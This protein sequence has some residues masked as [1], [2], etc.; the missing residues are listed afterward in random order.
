MRET[1]GI[2]RKQLR[3]RRAG[4][5][6][7]MLGQVGSGGFCHWRSARARNSGCRSR[8]IDCA[9]YNQSGRCRCASCFP[10]TTATSRRASSASPR[11]SRRTPRSPS[12][13]PKRDR[14]GASNSLTL[15]RP[16][17]VRRAPNGFLLRQ[18]HADRLRAP[19]GDRTPRR[20]AG[21]RDLGHQPRRE[22]GRRHDLLGHRRRG[23][24]RLPARHSVDRDLAR[25]EDG[26]AF[27]D[28]GRRRARAPRA[29]RAGMRWARW[30]LNVN[31]PDV[32][33]AELSGYRITRLG[34]RHK[35][36][37]VVKTKN[38]R[39]E[40]VYWVG[41]AGAAADAGRG[42]RF[43]RGRARLRVGHAAADRPHEPRRDAAGRGVAR[44]TEPDGSGDGGAMAT[45][46]EKHVG[47]RHDV[48]AHA[49]AH[50]RAAA[51]GGHPRR[52]RARG[53]ERGAA[54]HLR[55]RGARDPRLRG[56]AAADR[57]RPDDLAAVGRRADDRARA[58]R[59]RRSSACS[60]SAPAAAIR[61]PCSRR[62][63]TRSTPSS[64]SARSSRRRGATCSRSRSRT[65]G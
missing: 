10:T 2:A 22:H 60:R 37:N 29:P 23:D 54:P 27:R 17:T 40:T 31:V 62:S 24:R 11:R 9:R 46:G 43:P 18:R 30:L 19:R 25:V 6:A 8:I 38:P 51:R 16:L 32:P 57:Q 5:R 61:R 20:A 63:R 52:G 64:A 15:D 59:R 34:R 41:A 21:H 14:S 44:R 45:R 53:D 12:S 1:I 65:C 39:G 58:R 13:R 35:A 26:R 47:H 7:A 56:H 3:K 4:K 55:R 42:H 28:R 48:D 33:R 36:E 49:H 50:G